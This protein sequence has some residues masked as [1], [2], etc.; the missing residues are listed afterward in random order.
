MSMD[1]VEIYLVIAHPCSLTGNG[2][3][4]LAEDLTVEHSAKSLGC[5][6]DWQDRVDDWADVRGVEQVDQGA[7]LGSGAHR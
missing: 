6:G 5:V 2:E 1:V 3:D 4:D 7:E